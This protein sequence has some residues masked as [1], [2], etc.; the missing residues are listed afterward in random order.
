MLIVEVR[1]DT[2]ILKQGQISSVRRTERV[3]IRYIVR[4]FVRRMRQLETVPL[5]QHSI[6]RLQIHLT[7][8]AN[9]CTYVHFCFFYSDDIIF[10]GNILRKE[11]HFLSI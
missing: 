8:T 3:A 11:N 7:T 4:L 5:K 2:S 6:E 9:Y 10:R 1:V